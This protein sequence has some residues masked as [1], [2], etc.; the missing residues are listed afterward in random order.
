LLKTIE[1]RDMKRLCFALIAGILLITACT[2]PAQPAKLRVLTEEYPPFNYTDATGNLVGSS[3]EAVK[4]IISKLGENITIEVL[5]WS[6]SYEIVL[7]EPDVALY[8]MARTSE[9]ENLFMWVGPI[10]SYENWLYAK[11]GSNVRVSNIDEAKT[12]KC[13]AVVK[14]EAGQQNLAQQGC[15]NFAY[16]DSTAGGL[17]KLVAGEVDLWLGTGADVELVAKQAGVDPDEIEAVV[18]VHKVD[19]YIAFNKNTA[20]ATVLAWQNALDSLKK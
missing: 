9:R 18:F 19:L 5:P 6:Q 10:G 15:I 16:V 12:V 14:D 11:K 8:S 1:V 4:G 13:I 17:K 3:T 2:T 7:A 20:Y